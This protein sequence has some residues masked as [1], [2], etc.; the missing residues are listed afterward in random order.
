MPTIT[1]QSTR[2]IKFWKYILSISNVHQFNTTG[3]WNPT[4][5]NYCTIR[6]IIPMQYVDFHHMKFRFTFFVLSKILQITHL[7]WN[8]FHIIFDEMSMQWCSQQMAYFE[9]QYC[10]WVS[11]AHF[12]DFIC[13]DILMATVSNVFLLMTLDIKRLPVQMTIQS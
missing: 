11:Y 1:F 8:L 7:I 5:L 9:I 2:S 4:N 13:V 3:A 12:S 10:S 6:A